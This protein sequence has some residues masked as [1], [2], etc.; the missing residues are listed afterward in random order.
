MCPFRHSLQ[1]R[2]WDALR[3]RQV[4]FLQE[5]TRNKG[6]I[7]VMEDLQTGEKV[8]VKSMPLSWACESHEAFLEAHPD[9]EEQPW[10]DIMMSHFLS[11]IV[12]TS[13][14]CDFVGVYRREN[15]LGTDICM[16]ASYCPGGDLFSWME[17]CSEPIG[18]DRERV[19]QPIIQR[20]FQAVLSLHDMDIAHGDISLENVVLGRSDESKEQG[21]PI[22]LIDFAAS[23]GS[24]SN[25]LRGKPSY[26]APE[27]YDREPYDAFAADAFSLGVLVFTLVIG[28]YPWRST[29]PHLCPCFKYFARRGLPEYLSRR[30]IKV[31][32]GEHVCL[33]D[34]MSDS[35]K[36]L[37]V[38]LL[39]IDPAKRL[40]VSAALQHPWFTCGARSAA[41]SDEEAWTSTENTS[42]WH[43]VFYKVASK[44]IVR[45]FIRSTINAIMSMS[46]GM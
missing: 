3:F 22:R 32:D 16:V 46:S 12:R 10:R 35:L 13:F 44:G 40:T 18:P 45:K 28:N 7:D 43:G 33:S 23:T 27:M 37:L 38:G 21:P 2:D 26:Q 30:K 9:E 31:A 24:R 39:T 8:A 1:V 6:R 11:D 14:V 20:L 36:S 41:L 29:R 42:C 25:G 15:E 34:I 17:K 4:A 19:V 5:A